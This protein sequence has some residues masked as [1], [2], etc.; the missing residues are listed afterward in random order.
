MV[1]PKPKPRT[2]ER[3]KK[4]LEDPEL[5]KMIRENPEEWE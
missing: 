4:D 1:M 3:I 2:A 5:Q